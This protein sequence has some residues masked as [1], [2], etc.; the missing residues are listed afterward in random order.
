MPRRILV[1]AG[2]GL[3]V[4]AARHK[5]VPVV[6]ICRFGFARASLLSS[7]ISPRR[8]RSSWANGSTRAR[9]GIL[10]TGR[11]QPPNPLPIPARPIRIARRRGEGYNAGTMTSDRIISEALTLPVPD[12]LEIIERLWDSLAA[13]SD[14]LPLTE[15][16]RRELDRRISE[17]E[18]RPDA[19]IP[20]EAVKAQHRDAR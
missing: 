17:M 8:G 4:R 7:N 6:I 18:D 1:R 19:G 3:S 14:P 15:A 16:Q 20:W 2:A 9:A 11:S 12:R 13:S 10:Y 5:V